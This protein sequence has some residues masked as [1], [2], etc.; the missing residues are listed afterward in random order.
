M[1]TVQPE[2][3][4]GAVAANTDGLIESFTEKPQG[5]GTWINGGFFICQPEMFNY[6]TE[7][8]ATVF[9]RTPLENLAKDKQL[10]SYKHDGFWKCMDTLRDK[11]I[12]NNLWDSH[13]AKWKVW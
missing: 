9:E 13:Q 1:T 7:G 12:L 2:G 10:Y 4:F 5:D 8:N 6:L 11:I 3:R